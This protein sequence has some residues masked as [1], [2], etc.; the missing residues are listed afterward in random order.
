MSRSNKAFDICSPCIHVFYN[1]NACELVDVVGR[2]TSKGGC[3]GRDEE[4]L[5][6]K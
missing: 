6:R 4:F 3:D 1:T 2:K 5:A